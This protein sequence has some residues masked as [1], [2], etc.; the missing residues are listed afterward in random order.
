MALSVGEKIGIALQAQ[1][2]SLFDPSSQNR[3]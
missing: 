2:I 3:L 1:K